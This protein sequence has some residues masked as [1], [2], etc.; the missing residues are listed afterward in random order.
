MLRVESE[1][2]HAKDSLNASTTKVVAKEH[3]PWALIHSFSE[4]NPELKDE[5]QA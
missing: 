2:R 1:D 4:K 5:F 3:V